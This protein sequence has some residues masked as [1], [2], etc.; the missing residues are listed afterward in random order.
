MI[1]N[2]KKIPHLIALLS[3]TCLCAI[4]GINKYYNSKVLSQGT[5]DNFLQRIAIKAIL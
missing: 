1:F 4:K 2:K 3:A 5:H